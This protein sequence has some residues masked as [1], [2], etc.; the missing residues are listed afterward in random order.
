MGILVTRYGK[1]GRI[2]T[3]LRK[4]QFDF[5]PVVP[6]GKVA[7]LIVAVCFDFLD[8]RGLLGYCQKFVPL[9]LLLVPCC[10]VLLLKTKLL[11]NFDQSPIKT[12]Q[13]N[14]SFTI[15]NSNSHNILFHHGNLLSGVSYMFHLI[16]LLSQKV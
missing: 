5:K 2:T 14:K 1:T 8:V 9:L 10:Q 13:S 4:E 3:F 12:P 11:S 6:G 7:A 16:V 15:G